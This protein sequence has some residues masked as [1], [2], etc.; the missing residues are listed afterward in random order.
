[1]VLW[2]A[3][4]ESVLL[5]ELTVPWEEGIEAAQERKKAKYFDLV[6]ECREGGWSVRLCLVEV[7][8]RGFVGMTTTYLLKDLRLRGGRLQHATKERRGAR[9]GKLLPVA[10]EERQGVGSGRKSQLQGVSG[11][12]PR[13]AP[14]SLPH[15]QQMFLGKGQNI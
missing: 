1:M 3:A 4:S 14:C 12:R 9:E 6:M 8:T 5:V 13:E 10:E 15:H 2:A 7:G 11:R